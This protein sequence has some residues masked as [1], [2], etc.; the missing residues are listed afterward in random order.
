MLYKLRLSTGQVQTIATCSLE[1]GQVTGWNWWLRNSY[2][3][4]H[5]IQDRLEIWNKW[6]RK[7][8]TMAKIQPKDVANRSPFTNSS[9]LQRT[10][11]N[12]IY[13]TSFCFLQWRLSYVRVI[14][15]FLRISLC[16]EN[17]HQLREQWSTRLRVVTHKATIYRN[18]KIA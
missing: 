10:A 2:F 7:V 14:Q 8:N 4:T 6:I 5:W 16:T 15:M 13:F 11:N 1:L 18:I 3:P 17:S 9:S 12:E